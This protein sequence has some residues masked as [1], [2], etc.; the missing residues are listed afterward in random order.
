MQHGRCSKTSLSPD[1]EICFTDRPKLRLHRNRLFPDMVVA[2]S[3]SFEN[4]KKVRLSSSK[5]LVSLRKLAANWRLLF[6]FLPLLLVLLLL[7]LWSLLT[8][9]FFRYC[10]IHSSLSHQPPLPSS[11]FFVPK[12]EIKAV[13][14]FGNTRCWVI[15]LAF[16]RIK[17]WLQKVQFNAICLFFFM[18]TAKV[19]G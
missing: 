1:S 19:S 5:T 9:S 15:F 16:C 8:V 6:Y 4:K 3:F 17:G 14:V 10:N 12:C 2:P 7:L 18:S 11:N 13:D